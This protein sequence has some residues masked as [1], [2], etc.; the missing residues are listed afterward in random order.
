[1][2]PQLL[3]YVTKCREAGIA[4]GQIRQELS[5]AGWQIADI[6]EGLKTKG[7]GKIPPAVPAVKGQKPKTSS[8]AKTIEIIVLILLL[9]GTAAF[10]FYTFDKQ[11][12]WG[13]LSG[14]GGVQNQQ[15]EQ[16]LAEQ[17]V[18]EK[19]EVSEA[20]NP[21]I[22]EAVK[23]IIKCTLRTDPD[24]YEE[25]KCLAD[26]FKKDYG[27]DLCARFKE[28]IISENNLEG[29][30]YA[31]LAAAKGDEGL[32]SEKGGD[33]SYVCDVLI[34]GAK[35]E[36]TPE[37]HLS[38]C[39]FDVKCYASIFSEKGYSETACDKVT[40]KE[41]C[42][43]GAAVNKKD[44]SICSKI[45]DVSEKSICYSYVA[46]AKGDEKLCV[47][48]AKIYKGFVID[49]CYE[50]V[51]ITKKDPAACEKLSNADD[52]GY[53]YVMLAAIEQDQS[54]CLKTE[55][56]NKDMCYVGAA[57]VKEDE[58]LCGESGSSEPLCQT[59]LALAKLDET[60]C[61]GAGSQM[62]NCYLY[63]ARLKAE[64]KICENSGVEKDACYSSLAAIKKDKSFCA[65][66]GAL[67][68]ECEK[69]FGE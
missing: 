34:A 7:S 31:G 52:K 2:N 15:A 60:L 33:F 18:A 29:A 41:D 63:L 39:L 10:G 5:K 65:K 23:K 16:N 4:D 30:C 8:L 47:E 26:I 51:A 20:V 13:I 45:K 21:E 11:L 3:D 48:A 64:E 43:T 14:R 35:N 42:Y 57:I 27:E 54:F 46:E 67:Q 53:C 25:I 19:T 49:S 6:E 62:D 66:A 12:G 38:K 32:C 24:N 59:M 17:A 61:A 58:K 36:V 1:M 22:N 69:G 40:K 55:G 44:E 56:E 9:L 68:V 28:D 50:E 37:Q